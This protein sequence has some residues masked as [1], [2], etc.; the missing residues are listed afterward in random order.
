MTAG[1]KESM[2]T[3]YQLTSSHHYISA[4]ISYTLLNN[5]LTDS[6][7]FRMLDEITACIKAIKR[8]LKEQG[9]DENKLKLAIGGYS[10]S[11]HLALLYSYLIGQFNII[12]IEFLI[13]IAGPISLEPQYFLKL[14][15]KEDSLEDIKNI[16]I[17]EEAKNEGKLIPSFDEPTLLRISNLFFGN[18]YTVEELEEMLDEEGHIIK[19]NEKYQNMY[20]VIKYAFI[21]EI[22]KSKSNIDTLCFYGGLDETIGVSVFANLKEKADKDGRKLELIYS[23]YTK[24]NTLISSVGFTSPAKI[25]EI[26]KLVEFSHR[27]KKYAKK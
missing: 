18:N 21:T 9:F 25:H 23:R 8:E 26:E 22:E 20:K 7:I 6:N 3:F 17:I 1:S 10:A 16:S 13:N 11:A 4:T 14:N 5:Y 19:S 15:S 27:I 24:H 2:V 12:P